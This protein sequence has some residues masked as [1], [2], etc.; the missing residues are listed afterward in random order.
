MAAR[1]PKPGA[2]LMAQPDPTPAPDPDALQVDTLVDRVDVGPGWTT[3]FLAGD[4]IPAA[5][6]D[7]PRRPA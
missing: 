6:A 2:P 4:R 7:F 1:K 3:L 5:L